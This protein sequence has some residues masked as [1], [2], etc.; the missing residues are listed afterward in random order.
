M[1]CF[2]KVTI[3]FIFNINIKHL[4]VLNTVINDLMKGVNIVFPKSML[5][6]NI[7]EKK[8]IAM[9][10]LKMVFFEGCRFSVI[11]VTH[12]KVVLKA[13]GRADLFVFFPKLLIQDELKW[14]EKLPNM[15]ETPSS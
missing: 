3:S 13:T 5:T 15:N 14:R 7:N 2:P 11:R 9:S 1:G 10:L 6:Y 4:R 12:K 8:K